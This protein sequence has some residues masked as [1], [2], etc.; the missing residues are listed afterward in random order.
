MFQVVVCE[1]GTGFDGDDLRRMI[2]TAGLSL[3][4]TAKMPSNHTVFECVL[5]DA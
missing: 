1:E 3:V 2:E 5:P 4:S